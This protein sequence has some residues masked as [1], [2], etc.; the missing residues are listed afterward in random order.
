ML[1]FIKQIA[2]S[3]DFQSQNQ[4]FQDLELQNHWIRTLKNVRLLLTDRPIY[5]IGTTRTWDILLTPIT[6]KFNSLTIF[7]KLSLQYYYT[8]LELNCN[9]DDPRSWKTICLKGNQARDLTIEKIDIEC[10]LLSFLR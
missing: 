2:V 5:T 6:N 9:V 7:K 1:F 4:S 3:C 8:S 10:V